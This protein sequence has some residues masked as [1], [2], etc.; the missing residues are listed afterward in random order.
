MTVTELL[1]FYGY[2][3][4]LYGRALDSRIEELMDLLNLT[5]YRTRRFDELSTGTKQ[6]VALSKA[7]INS[8]ELLFLDEPTIGLDPDVAAKMRAFVQ[9]INTEKKITILLTTHYMAEAEQLA[10]R[11]AFL[12]KGRIMVEGTPSELKVKMQSTTMEQLFMELSKNPLS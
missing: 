7:L 9:R 1:K 2:L 10:Q 12:Q 3:Y 5:Q 11:I 4:G 8:P 6:R